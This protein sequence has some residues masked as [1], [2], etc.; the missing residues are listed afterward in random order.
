MIEIRYT[1]NWKYNIFKRS[2]KERRSTMKTTKRTIASSAKTSS[3]YQRILADKRAMRDYFANIDPSV[4]PLTNDREGI[5]SV[6]VR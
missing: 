6:S 3:A 2:I 4:G 1:C 5:Q